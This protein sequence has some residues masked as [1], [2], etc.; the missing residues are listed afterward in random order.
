MQH[1]LRWPLGYLAVFLCFL[2]STEPAKASFLVTV[3]VDSNTSVNISSYLQ[4]SGVNTFSVNG[5]GSYLLFDLNTGQ[6]IGTSSSVGSGQLGMQ[7]SLT[8]NAPGGALAKL[9]NATTN[10]RNNGGGNGNL[11]V[12]ITASDTFTSPTGN[13]TLAG[14]FTTS[15]ARNTAF[16]SSVL[17]GSTT[18]ASV[19]GTNTSNPF[20]V[21]GAYTLMNVTSISKLNP[22][23]TVQTTGDSTVSDPPASPAPEPASLTIILTSLP[24]V[25]FAAWRNR[26]KARSTAQ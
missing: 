17:Q 5:N 3:Q 10:V 7:V 18:L 14:D 1:S 23:S 11:G 21:T 9:F 16:T 24:L 12:T 26:R 15:D 19:S 8:D 6:V 2:S 20:N 13:V 22:N 4:S 25:G